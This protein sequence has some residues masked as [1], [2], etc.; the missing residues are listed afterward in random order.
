MRNSKLWVCST[1][2]G[3]FLCCHHTTMLSKII[4][5]F[6]NSNHWDFDFIGNTHTESYYGY[7]Q[8]SK[9]YVYVIFHSNIPVKLTDL[10]FLRCYNICWRTGWKSFRTSSL[11][12]ISPSRASWWVK[13]TLQNKDLGPVVR[14]PISINPGLNFNPCP[15]YF[16]SKAFSQT[17]FS[18]LFRVANRQICWQKEL[19]WICFLSFHIWIQI[20]NYKPWVILTQLWTTWPWGSFEGV[21]VNNKKPA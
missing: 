5:S 18:I 8:V 1:L 12:T 6:N 2:F 9:H 20:A 15:F 14:R 3:R 21:L 19:N 13:N 17:I 10:L 11:G 4:V 16:S 7:F